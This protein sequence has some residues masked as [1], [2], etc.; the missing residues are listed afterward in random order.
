MV[1]PR[2][3]KLP[4]D[5]TPTLTR[6]GQAAIALAGHFDAVLA[7]DRADAVG[8]RRRQGAAAHQPQ[9][10]LTELPPAVAQQRALSSLV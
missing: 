8:Q 4:D 7:V 2:E 5:L 10:T 1:L 3:D 6:I 9:G